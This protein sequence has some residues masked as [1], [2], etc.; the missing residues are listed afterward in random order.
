MAHFE[1]EARIPGMFV[2]TLRVHCSHCRVERWASV[3]ELAAR[4]QCEFCG[5]Q[6]EL[7]LSHALTKPSWRYRLAAHLRPDQV[8]ALLP[9][10]AT[11][12]LLGQFRHVEEPPLA[13]LHGL[14]LRFGEGQLEADIA[15]YV[16]DHD[17]LAVIG[18][19]KSPNRI[20]ETDIRNLEVSNGGYGRRA[21]GRSHS[22]QR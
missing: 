6:F 5:D 16:P 15:A 10:L 1:K 8:Q 14:K 11:A 22:S 9:A 21:C 4:M 2:P 12:S 20:D 19:V 13:H 17:W 18:E 7:S 3:D